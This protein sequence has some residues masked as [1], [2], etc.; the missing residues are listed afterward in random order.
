MN[1]EKGQS[2]EE[3]STA[4]GNGE[5]HEQD[6]PLSVRLAEA[7]DLKDLDQP[8]I[9]IGQFLGKIGDDSIHLLQVLVCLPFCLPAFLPGWGVIAGCVVIYSAY[10]QLKDKPL[11]LPQKIKDAKIAKRKFAKVLITAGKFIGFLEKWISPRHTT[12]F[13]KPS[14][15]KFHGWL[16]VLVGVLLW[17][18]WPVI[19]PLS[20][21]FPGIAI[22]ILSLCLMEHDGRT[23]WIAYFLSFLSLIYTILLI[24]LG[25]EIG[26]FVIKLLDFS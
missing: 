5:S 17:I 6:H 3:D 12:F 22:V 19:F 10:Y 21:F 11:S 23:I 14:V 1:E 26:K 9:S 24:Y 7:L 18:P 15:I 20:N 4:E 8:E 25:K 2:Q 13:E 16:M